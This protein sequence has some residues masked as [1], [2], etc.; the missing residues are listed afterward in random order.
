MLSGLLV[1]ALSAAP[2]QP[3]APAKAEAPVKAPAAAKPSAPQKPAAPAKAVHPLDW[4]VPGL[5]NTI[6]IPGQMQVAGIPVRFR[7][8]TSREKLETLLQ[9]FATAFDEAGFYIQRHQKR[10]TAE[11]HLTALDTRSLTSYTVM[12]S[13]EPGGLI[14]VVVGEAKLKEFKPVT[15]PDALPVFPGAADVLY[16]NFE[17]ARTLGYRVAATE[18]EVRAWYQ[19]RLARDGFQ[20]EAPLVFRRQQ[21]ELHVS[22]K[23][24]EGQLSV[25]L[26][27]QTVAE[28]PPLDAAPRPATP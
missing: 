2:T 4:P 21:Q 10:R 18:A 24:Q 5:V 16:S 1:L 6:D 12:L 22:L 28:A 8:H 17:G 20:E 13:P 7:V 15:P 27:Y 3:Q 11:P 19:Q 25:M 26:F 23:P 9:H 14:T